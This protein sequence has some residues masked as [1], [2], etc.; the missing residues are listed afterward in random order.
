M[1]KSIEKLRQKP[2]HIRRAVALFVTIALFLVILFVWFS[3]LNLGDTVQKEK[4]RVAN[5]P[6]PF[7]NLK[8]T[9]GGI[10]NDV[11]EQAESIN[12]RFDGE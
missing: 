8:D 6:T 11:T 10:F 9:L 4:D 12:G 3:T 5:T 2:E 7:A 1:F